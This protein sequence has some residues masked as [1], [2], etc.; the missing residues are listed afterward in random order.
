[1][2]IG[3]NPNKDKI[4]ESNDFFHQ[5]IVPVYIPNQE[6]YFKDSFQ[7]LRFCLESLFKTCHGQTYITVVNNGSCTEVIDYLNQLY[8]DN[9]IKEIIH[10]DN[11]GKLNAILKG[12]TGHNFPLITISDADVLFL[13]HWQKETNAV[14]DAFPQAGAV[15]PTP[16]S[17]TLR[18]HTGNVILEHLF[19]NGMKFSAV[20]NPQDL[21]KFA[22]SIGNPDFYNEVH[23]KKNL[24][25]MAANGI[26]AVIGAGHFVSSYRSEVFNK[27][28][29][30]YS[31]FSLGGNSERILLDVPVVQ[32]D[33]WRLSTQNTYAYHMGNIVEPW[34]QET[35][36]A[37]VNNDPIARTFEIRNKASKSALKIGL[38]SF[39]FNKIISRKLIWK[40]FLQYKGLTKEEAN[41]Y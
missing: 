29:K 10:T 26:S 17:K 25:V 41:K 39:I 13:S 22:E 33:Y 3:F 12:I 28:S 27:I 36:D 11:I 19:S 20:N 9:K 5:V 15:S 4:Q 38:Q 34:M 14:F 21:R 35:I 32:N 18:Q 23:L 7:I 31:E 16:S 40:L 30:R 8:D 6:G 1:M 2:R 37:L 24:T